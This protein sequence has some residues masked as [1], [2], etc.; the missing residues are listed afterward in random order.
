MNPV[1]NSQKALESSQ[2]YSPDSKLPRKQQ[3]AI[4]NGMNVTIINDSRDDNAAGRQKIRVYNLFGVAPHFIG[5]THELEAAGNIIDAL[6]ALGGEKGVILVNIAPRNGAAKKWKNGTPF[7]YFRYRNAL[8]VSAV[9]GLVLSLVKKFGL[10][11]AL[12]VLDTESATALLAE[13]EII[14]PD[15]TEHIVKSQFRSFDFLPRIGFCLSKHPTLEIGEPVPITSFPDAPCVVWYIDNF[16]NVKTTLTVEDVHPDAEGSVATKFGALRFYGRLK[17]V[18]EG[19]AAL[20]IGSS[21][22]GHK[23][24]LE[25]V[26]QGRSAEKEFGLAVGSEI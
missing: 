23:R 26:V 12:R 9:D 24:F 14:S 20:I 25:V 7:G 16:G 13:K 22:L 10:C 3:S 6:D 17:D 15:T 4:S 21:G 8:M 18:P 1:R 5:V 11:H 2:E 19:E